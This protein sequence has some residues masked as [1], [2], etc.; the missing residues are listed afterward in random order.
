M[1]VSLKYIILKYTQHEQLK[2]K[3]VDIV[4]IYQQSFRRKSKCQHSK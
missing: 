2:I 1:Y 4:P 3:I